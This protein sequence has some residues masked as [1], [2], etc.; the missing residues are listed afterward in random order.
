MGLFGGIFGLADEGTDYYSGINVPDPEQMKLN[1]EEY[2]SQGIITPE[3]ADAILQDPSQFTK[4]VQS[5]QF[6]DAQLKALQGLQDVASQGGM[7]AID[8]AQLNDIANQEATQS[9]GSREAIMANAAEKGVGGSGLEMLSQMKNQQESTN[10]A[11]NRGSDVAAAAQQRAL[12]ALIQ[13]GQMGES[14]GN[15]EFRQQA[16]IAAAKDAVNRFN[17]S[18]LNETEKYNVSARNNASLANLKAKQGIAD[19]N[20]GLRNT[21]QQYNKELLQKEFENKYKKAGGQGDAAERDRK[22]KKT[23]V[24]DVEGGVAD[25]FGGFSGGFF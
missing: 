12:Q 11:A 3:A 10:R 16:D 7:T 9:R 15:S 8:K 21:A 5:P 17:T 1:L 6:K 18:N 22:F 4:I 2:V 20:V 25:L 23:A 14:M 19:S 13:G 24:E